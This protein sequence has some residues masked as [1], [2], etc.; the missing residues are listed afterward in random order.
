MCGIL[1]YSGEK[2]ADNT[3][4]KILFLYSATRGTH[5][6]GFAT[7]Y[8][9]EKENSTAP[10][11][12][13]T[14]KI[15][16]S[17]L[18]IGHT[19]NPSHNTN[20][21]EVNAQPFGFKKFSGVHN[22]YFRNSYIMRN[23]HGISYDLSDSYAFFHYM[24]ESSFKQA[25]S[26]TSNSSTYAVAWIDNETKELHLFR[27]AKPIYIGQKNGGIYFASE[28]E[29]LEAIDCQNISSVENRVHYTIKDGVIKNKE[30]I[31]MSKASSN[32]KQVTGY[33]RY[34]NDDY[35]YSETKYDNVPKIGAQHAPNDAHSIFIDGKKLYY[36]IEKDQNKATVKVETCF[37][38]KNSEV[39]EYI[40]S[41]KPE[42]IRLGKEYRRIL[43]NV[44]KMLS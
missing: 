29:F 30:S 11:F 34:D 40:V 7:P 28:K 26:K 17:N 25:I 20:T 42:A 12:I 16:S 43:Q 39:K 13:A 10:Y 21:K 44:N 4:I 23:V 6:T 8:Q 37:S 31:P 35:D 5:S 27:D 22:G 15:P 36:W 1:G 9:L 33:R 2:P 32:T 38:Y 18:I 14:N 24:H 41:R 3:D 19:R